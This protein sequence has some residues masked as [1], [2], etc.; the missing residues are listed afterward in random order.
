MDDTGARAE[1]LFLEVFE[2]LPRQGPGRRACTARALALCAGLPEAPLVLDLGCGAGAQTLHLA[3][4]TAGRIVALDLHR[5][6]VARLGATLAARGLERRVL[7]AW[8]DMARPP[9]P[10]GRCDLVWSEG[11]LYNLGLA[12]A[13]PLVRELLRPGGHV[14]FT[15][16]VW[17][18]ADPP[19]EVREAF[20]EYATMGTAAD[21]LREIEASGLAPV[22]H[23]PVPDEAWWDDFYTPLLRRVGELRAQHAGDAEALAA[24]DAIAA[25]AEMHRRHASSYGYDFFVA[26]RP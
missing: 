18:V 1:E 11:A 22:G 16:A 26:R 13:L 12:R 6:N 2:S 17:R 19:A 20:A 8:G 5:P 7:A 4:L 23:F 21:A 14:A 10:P 24:L 9:V 25:E 15:D 3:E